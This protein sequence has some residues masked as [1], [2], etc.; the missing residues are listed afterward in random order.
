MYQ[1]W[2]NC[3]DLFLAYAM[4]KSPRPLRIK[5]SKFYQIREATRDTSDPEN[6]ISVGFGLLTS[7]RLK[8]MTSL[9]QT[10]HITGH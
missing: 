7:G 8:S 5:F 4:K 2:Y 9:N 6:W 1:S 3:I 10:K